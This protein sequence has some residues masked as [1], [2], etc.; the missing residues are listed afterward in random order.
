MQFG[1]QFENEVILDSEL[2]S[3]TA[4]L[5]W[6]GS[7]PSRARLLALQHLLDVLFVLHGPR[8]NS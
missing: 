2:D 4:I 7:P 1:R 6:I 5:N 8:L 3:N